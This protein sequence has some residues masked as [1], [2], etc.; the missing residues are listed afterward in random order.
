MSNSSKYSSDK[1]REAILQRLQ[2]AKNTSGLI[3]DRSQ[4]TDFFPPTQDVLA[5]FV[6]ECEK[7][8][9]RV[10]ICA[11]EQEVQHQLLLL[12]KEEGWENILCRDKKLAKYLPSGLKML[13]ESDFELLNVGITACEFLI[14]RSGSILV[15]SGQP[16]G[17]LLNIFPPVHVVIARANQL[18]PFIDDALTQY[19]LKYKEC[20]PSQATVITGPSRTADIEKTL[21]M[22]AHGPKQLIVLIHH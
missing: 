20:L 2:R 12:Q 22:G 21:V 11:N 1:A 13:Q 16:S 10:F 9:G 17:R 15:S 3:P 7:V 14:A 18:V 8:N 4:S 5:T 6:E 19:K